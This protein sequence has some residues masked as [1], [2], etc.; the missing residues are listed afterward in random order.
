MGSSEGSIMLGPWGGPAGEQK[1]SF[2]ASGGITKI[3]IRQ[4]LNIKS[5]S[6]QDSHGYNSGTFGGLNTNDVG[7]ETSFEI[8][9][10]SEYL[11]SITGSYGTYAGMLVITSLSFETNL[12]THGPFGTLSG[13]SF[14]IP[15]EGSV[16]VGFHGT[17]GHYLDS[18]GIYITPGHLEGSVSFGPWGGP[19]G[20]PWSFKASNGINEIVLR[21]G[22]TINSISFI[23]ANGH[24]S[25]ILGGLDPDDVGV[26]EKIA[27]NWPLEHLTS[28]SGSY[29]NY[30]NH[31]MI[32]SLTFTTNRNTYGPYGTT[33]GTATS[34]DVP[35][36]AC[37]V[38]GLHGRAG[39]YI[40]AIGIY[41]KPWDLGER[42]T[43]GPWG[44]DGGNPFSFI[45]SHGIN[46]III[47]Q[48]AA[49][50]IK[51]I[52]FRDTSGLHS[53]TFGGHNP[54]DLVNDTKTIDIHWPTEHLVSISGTYGNYDGQLVI[55]SLSFTT[56]QAS[57]G[58]FGVNTGTP[59][60]VPMEGS[61][62]VGFY[63]K[64]GWYLDRIGVIV[65]A[66]HS[67]SI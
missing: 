54:N 13:T 51:S 56:N 12:T 32:T 17:S 33:S 8:K 21:H 37:I 44:G 36:H 67:E 5:I 30:R 52:A 38:V 11:T 64:A 55:R 34:F 26:E 46:E 60:S 24:H 42:I 22:G 19:S 66:M 6:F 48:G 29:G 58:P 10:P 39:W 3:V 53:G 9:W 2:R 43:M 49:A 28:I 25:P 4:G 27:I 16:V 50:N 14:S 45:A 1:W 59:F 31:L 15:M 23:D 20:D 61:H 40:D 7:E 41:V 18:L 47:H 65:K 57:Y 63:G 62:I 35:V